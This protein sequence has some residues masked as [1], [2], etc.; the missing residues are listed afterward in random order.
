MCLGV[1]VSGF[2]KSVL[3][4]GE[5]VNPHAISRRRRRSKLQASRT[6]RPSLWKPVPF[7]KCQS[8]QMVCL[9]FINHGL[10]ELEGLGDHLVRASY[11]GGD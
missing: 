6:G 8:E 11:R 7:L 9:S 5:G 3:G 10:M 1:R 4:R 2:S